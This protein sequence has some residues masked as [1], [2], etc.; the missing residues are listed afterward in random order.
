MRAR[1]GGHAPETASNA[2][3]S[4]VHHGPA[5]AK[6][7]HRPR[8]DDHDRATPPASPNDHDLLAFPARA[9]PTASC[10]LL[11]AHPHAQPPAA[12]RRPAS[13]PPASCLGC[14]ACSWQV[15]E[16]ESSAKRWTPLPRKPRREAESGPEAGRRPV[17]FLG[18][19]TR[20][21]HLETNTERRTGA[22]PSPWPARASKGGQDR[23]SRLFRTEGHGA[24][25]AH[26]HRRALDNRGC[27]APRHPPLDRA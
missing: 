5:S 3:R 10:L 8:D 6:R 21:E 18:R 23:A 19:T 12:C 27:R 15:E 25:T 9:T 11:L 22:A 7:R 26:P 16:G 14:P 2:P 1:S 24:A 20:D 17:R 4:R 13:G